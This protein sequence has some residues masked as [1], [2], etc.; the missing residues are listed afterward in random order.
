M[1]WAD[2]SYLRRGNERQQAAHAALTSLGVMAD[3]GA[4]GSVLCGTIP[5]G[6][7]LPESDLDIICEA[8]DLGGFTA[9]VTALYGGIEGFAV[10]QNVHQGLPAVIAGFTYGGFAF[11]LFGQPRPAR[12]QNAYRHMVAEARLL[13]LA[14]PTAAEA[15]R[16][17]KASGLKTEPAFAAYF[18][19]EGDPYAVL[20][21]L[22]DADDERLSA[23]RN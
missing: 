15:I 6:V 3:L 18:G 7:D 17:L 9:R 21:D 2:I 10:R 14:G 12:E 16:G 4:Y 11:E 20:L 13:A 23:R 19:L 5:L 22:A 8:R 1:D